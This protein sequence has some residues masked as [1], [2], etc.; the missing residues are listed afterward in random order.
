M[1]S[2]SETR[3]DQWA[4]DDQPWVERVSGLS[5]DE[6]DRR[7]RK[8][9]RPVILTD[10]SR[11]WPA[12]G[13]YSFEYFKR[14]HGDRMLRVQGHEQ[15]LAAVID[16]LIASTPEDP[17][18]Y[19]CT[20]PGDRT[21]YA[22]LSPR[23][24]HA[25]PTRIRN[26]LVPSALFNY[27]NHLE[28]LFGAPGGRFPRLHFNLLH[29]HTFSTQALGEMEFTIYAP[30]QEALLYV[31]PATPWMSSVKELENPDPVKFPLLR[32]A[33]KQT[34][35]VREGETL[36]IPCGIWHTARCVTNSISVAFD[37]LDRT[38]WRDF[39]ADSVSFQRQAGQ[40]FKAA[41]LATWL[42]MIG[43]VLSLQETF[44]RRPVGGAWT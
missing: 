39:S 13:R 16:Q 37:H 12:H 42:S 17:G 3:N 18:P 15:R 20:L 32:Q 44:R 22:D 4:P 14:E 23:F 33:R 38:N 21:L 34:V 10:V 5:V 6:F 9:R 24:P 8:P 19:P 7:Y 2:K 36:F 11:D 29:L 28:V 27:G 31:N 25:S 1:N 30:G 40:P 41:L 43:P 26:E 35:L